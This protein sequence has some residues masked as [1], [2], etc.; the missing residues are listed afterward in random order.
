VPP[1]SIVLLAINRVSD[2]HPNNSTYFAF[3]N[4]ITTKS[5]IQEHEYHVWLGIKLQ[6]YPGAEL[7]NI[8]LHVRMLDESNLMQQEAISILGIN[9]I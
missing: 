4:T 2:K 3:A 5:Y 6:I 7:C 8:C 9:L 1:A